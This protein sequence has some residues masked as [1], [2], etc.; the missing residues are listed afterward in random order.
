MQDG[1]PL[2]RDGPSAWEGWSC[3][4][5]FADSPSQRSNRSSPN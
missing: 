2:C 1:P 5:I 3:Y 4:C